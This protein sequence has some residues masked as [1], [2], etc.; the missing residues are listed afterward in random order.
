MAPRDESP[1]REPGPAG[2][3]PLAC[4]VPSS[5]HN[6]PAAS[7]RCFEHEGRARRGQITDVHEQG[8]KTCFSA[9]QRLQWA[10]QRKAAERSVPVVTKVTLARTRRPT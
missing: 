3:F 5:S 4:V 6:S 1:T 8:G 2:N 9:P 10:P 7:Q